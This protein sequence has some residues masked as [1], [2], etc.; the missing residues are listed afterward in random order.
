MSDSIDKPGVEVVHLPVGT[1]L[2]EAERAVIMATFKHHRGNMERTAATL[3]CSLKTLYNRRNAYGISA[4]DLAAMSV[5]DGLPPLPSLS[6]D[7]RAEVVELI[8]ARIRE[9][10]EQLKAAGR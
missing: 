9:L 1:T 4:G 3:G 5:G 6:P 10:V 8:E 7:A 2:A